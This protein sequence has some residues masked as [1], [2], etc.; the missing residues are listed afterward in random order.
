MSDDLIT[1]ENA[2]LES[3]RKILDAALYQV[4]V[5]DNDLVVTASYKI[6]VHLADTKR[7]VRFFAG[8]RFKEGSSLAGRF[9]LANKINDELIMMRAC[10]SGEK[11]D[12]LWLDDYIWLD[13]GVSNRNIALAFK[14]FEAL[15]QASLAKDTADLIA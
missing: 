3:L 8:F 1:A 13:G 15:V 2:S 11:Q 6:W 5:K 4:A 14:Q 12:G 10:V 7:H 9:A